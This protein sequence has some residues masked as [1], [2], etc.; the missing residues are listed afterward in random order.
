MNDTM[1][2][3]VM[4]RPADIRVEDVAR[5]KLEPGHVIL[6]VAACGVCGSD[7]DRMLSK[8][9]HRMPLICGH[10]FSGW[11][12]EIAD[13]VDG[14]REGDLVTVPPLIPC[15]SCEQCARGNFSLCE[16]YDYFGSRRDGAYAEFV[17]VP[18]TNLL[19][20]PD[21]LDPA[22]AAMVDPAAIALHAIWR[23]EL[24]AG[25]RVAV[26]GCGPIGLFAIQWARMAGVS[27]VLA[28]DVTAPKLEMARQAGATM[29]ASTDDDALQ[30]GLYDLV[31]EAA[32]VPAAEDLAV[33]LVA[34]GGAAS[35]VGI[36]NREVLLGA[37]SFEHFLRQEIHLLGSWN[38]FSAPFPGDEWRT[39]LAKM[40]SGDLRWQFMV[41]HDLGIEK[42][43]AV[44][45]VLGERSE[46]TSKVIFRPGGPST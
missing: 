11:V 40:A 33:R 1:R 27:E 38:S 8:G 3:A 24:R 46:F 2:A 15:F 16:D 21:G 12:R 36:P 22:A 34:P 9:A 7:I 17:S 43:P 44:F 26:V 6:Q 20:V 32:G 29:T 45:E 10:E 23:W 30:T 41:T 28:V 39:T 25:Q 42:L 18:S 31:V 13:D 35:F 5:P 19:R 14:V 4:H 37:T